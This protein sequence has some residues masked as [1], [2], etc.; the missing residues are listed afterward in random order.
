MTTH[1]TL[2]FHRRYC[3]F[4]VVITLRHLLCWYVDDCVCCINVHVLMAVLSARNCL[5]WVVWMTLLMFPWLCWCV[6]GMQPAS[7]HSYTTNYP[8]QDS[9]SQEA[10]NVVGKSESSVETSVLLP[11]TPLLSTVAMFSNS[12]RSSCSLCK[13]KSRYGFELFS[14]DLYSPLFLVFSFPTHSSTSPTLNTILRTL[15]TLDILMCSES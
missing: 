6:N 15:S 12:Y 1:R 3:T 14:I 8:S 10:S 9:A 11:L 5:L 7:H 2:G 13:F 4:V